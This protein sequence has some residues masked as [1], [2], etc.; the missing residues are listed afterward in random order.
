LPV[1]PTGLLPASRKAWRVWFTAWFAAHWGPEDL[2]GLRHVILLYDQVERGEY[3]RAG[4]LRIQMD[5]YGLT[6]KGQQDRRWK[7]PADEE[8]P[9]AGAPPSAPAPSSRRAQLKVV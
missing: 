7:K 8:Q 4:E 1:A 2:P 6:P 3:Q 9:V 5:T